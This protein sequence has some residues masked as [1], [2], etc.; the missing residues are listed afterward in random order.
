MK[1]EKADD[2][3]VLLDHSIQIGNEKI[4]LIYG[5]RESRIDFFRP[6]TLQD[7]TPFVIKV[8]G[9]W[10]GNEVEKILSK[11]KKEIGT[12]KYA[13]GDYGSD[14]KKGLKLSKIIHIHDITHRIALI[15]EKM[16]KENDEY[17]RFTKKM[18]RMRVELSQSK[19][20]LIIPPK[21]KT[22][23]RY[24][25]IGL[26]SDWGKKVLNVIDN[27]LI[28]DQELFKKLSWVKK[29]KNF[30]M[31]LNEIN[32][33]IKKIEKITKHNCISKKTIVTCLKEFEKITTENGTLLKEKMNNYFNEIKEHLPRLNKVLCTSDI[34]E[35]AFG[36]YKRYVSNNPMA[37]VTNLVLSLAAFT[38]DLSDEIIIKAFESS[39]IRKITEWTKSEIGDSVLKRRRLI[40]KG[41]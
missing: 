18:S 5:V 25:N 34:I 15:I 17:L 8:Q 29:Y 16:Y 13:V 14:I 37:G 12:I 9:K 2:W 35:S 11:L 22:K 23:S 31:E 38:S 41:N 10:N 26:I 36:K 21:Q 7:L 19:F 33:I 27:R 40:F 20:A 30:I 39:P 3:I 1:K 6:L 4:F 28:E 24:Q 32:N